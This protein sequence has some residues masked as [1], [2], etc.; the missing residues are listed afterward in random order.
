[1]WCATARRQ[2]RLPTSGPTEGSLTVTPSS[3]VRGLGVYIDC[4]LSMRS[5]VRRTVSCCFA[6]LCQLRSIRRQIRTTVCQSVTV[7]LVL[8]RLDYC[9]SVLIGLPAC[10]IKCLQSVQN[11]AA[12]LVFRIMTYALIGL[13]W[14]RV[15]ERISY[16]SLPS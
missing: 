7:A 8:S 6:V 15:P 12:R 13:H 9:N 4:D 10:Y 2:H 1:M 11:A 14:L 3:S 16:T 5:H